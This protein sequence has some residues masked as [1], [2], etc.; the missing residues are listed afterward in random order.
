MQV[1]SEIELDKEDSMRTLSEGEIKYQT[2]KVINNGSKRK[3]NS[4]DRN[5]NKKYKLDMLIQKDY[6]SDALEESKKVSP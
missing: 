4:D 1:F 5:S 3:A 2:D 6:E